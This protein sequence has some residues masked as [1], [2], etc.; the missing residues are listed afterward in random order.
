MG[1]LVG[2]PILHGPTAAPFDIIILSG[3]PKAIKKRIDELDVIDNIDDVTKL[4][5]GYVTVI[6]ASVLALTLTLRK[7]TRLRFSKKLLRVLEKMT[8]AIV[9]QDNFRKLSRNS[10]RVL[11]ASFSV[12]VFIVVTCYLLNYLSSDLVADVYSPVI[13]SL[14][15]LM[16]TEFD[17]VTPIILKAYTAHTFIQKASSDSLVGQFYRKLL[18]DPENRIMEAAASQ[19]EQMIITLRARFM[20]GNS[21]MIISTGI[22]D[23]IG[24][25]ILC[26]FDYTIVENTHRSKGGTFGQGVE[27]KMMSKFIGPEMRWFLDFRFTLMLEAGIV[28]PE[29]IRWRRN[30]LDKV[31]ETTWDVIKCLGHV[32]VEMEQVVDALPL[33]GL[34][35]TIF[36]CCGVVFAAAV[37]VFM[38]QGYYKKF[39]K[40]WH[41]VKFFF[42]ITEHEKC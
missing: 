26:H 11:W 2:E 42:F 13:D 40:M 1:S 4:Y 14:E 6:M 15:D 3:K 24:E 17:H 18:S 12:Y 25:H 32:E 33:I 34:F 22:Y 5:L 9:T 10:S 21:S 20:A 39:L 28:Y 16:S 19:G 29:Y 7:R 37:T 27:T 36:V 23:A 30:T 41:S 38:E 35:R 31:F 8:F